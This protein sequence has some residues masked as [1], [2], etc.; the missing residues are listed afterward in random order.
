M[1]SILGASM[2]IF[3]G[4]SLR[5]WELEGSEK[6]TENYTPFLHKRG[7]E[8]MERE[9]HICILKMHRAQLSFFFG[10]PYVSQQG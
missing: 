10:C 7:K 5:V 8:G 6:R 1:M 9:G 4:V 2:G 3:L